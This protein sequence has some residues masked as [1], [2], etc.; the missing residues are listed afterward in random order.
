MYDIRYRPGSQTG[1]G[2]PYEGNPRQA[3]LVGTIIFIVVILIFYAM[4]NI[5]VEPPAGTRFTTE[6]WPPLFAQQR[7]ILT[8]FCAIEVDENTGL[9]S[10]VEGSCEPAADV[11]PD[12]QGNFDTMPIDMAMNQVLERDLLKT[13]PISG[14]LNMT[15]TAEAAGAEAVPPAA[16]PAQE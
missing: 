12:Q 5:P 8:G 9:T 7:D 11:T 6:Q 3:V 10:I 14:T 15:G 1:D 2:P 13:T 16:V 4:S